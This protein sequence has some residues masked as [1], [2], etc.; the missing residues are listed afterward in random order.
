V[1]IG[2]SLRRPNP[3]RLRHLNEASREAL[4][5]SGLFQEN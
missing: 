4:S 3:E 5:L 2:T 1:L